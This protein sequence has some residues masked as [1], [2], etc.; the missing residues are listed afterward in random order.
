M[1]LVEAALLLSLFGVVLAVGLP[2]FVRGLRT[3]KTAEAPHELERMFAAVAAYYEA[4]QATPSGTRMRCLP[5]PAGPT[6][7]QP[8]S[9][10]VEVD[11]AAPD[12]PGSA[13]WRAIG[14]AP[15]GAIRFR[16][17][18][19]PVEA[20]CGTHRP[21]TQ[22]RSVV[23]LRAEGDLDGDGTLSRFERSASVRDGRLVLEPLLIV[24][25]RI[26]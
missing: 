11:F 15:S 25:D 1:T 16:Y 10:P 9:D 8:S 12:A 7:A 3:S 21:D 19:V 4:P 18:L 24:R 20:G 22:G 5:A 6:P 26:E 17:S 13:T 23:T 2:A 14:Y